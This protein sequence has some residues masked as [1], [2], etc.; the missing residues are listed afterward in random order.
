M[1]RTAQKID[2]ARE[3]RIAFRILLA[4]NSYTNEELHAAVAAVDHAA[5]VLMGAIE[6]L[7]VEIR[8]NKERQA[9]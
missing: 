5:T 9:S 1:R 4:S 2:R 6:E 8:A 7:D 3:A